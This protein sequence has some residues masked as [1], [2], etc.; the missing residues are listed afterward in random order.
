MIKSKADLIEF[1]NLSIFES[2]IKFK[3]KT[4]F[5]HWLMELILKQ[6]IIEQVALHNGKSQVDD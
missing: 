6:E 2:F 1:F 3:I 5:T 4:V